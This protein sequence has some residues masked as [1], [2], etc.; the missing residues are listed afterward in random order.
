MRLQTHYALCIMH[1]L[2]YLSLAQ[3]NHNT[4]RYAWQFESLALDEHHTVFVSLNLAS[5]LKQS[6]SVL[7]NLYI[8][9]YNC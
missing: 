7:F 6:I 2:E 8:V 5:I 1:L 4:L 9:L 3:S